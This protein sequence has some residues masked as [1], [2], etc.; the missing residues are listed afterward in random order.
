[1][2][3]LGRSDETCQRWK[4]TL[5]S[6]SVCSCL[7]ICCACMPVSDLCQPI[8][9]VCPD[10][11]L[12]RRVEQPRVC[13]ILINASMVIAHVSVFCILMCVRLCGGVAV[14]VVSIGMNACGS[15]SYTSGL[16]TFH[17][18]Y[19]QL[20]PYSSYDFLVFA[21]G[22]KKREIPL[23]CYRTTDSYYVV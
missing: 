22:Y 1:M 9:R 10:G 4:R 21:N 11:W 15:N 2:Q 20:Y 17:N 16:D 8:V 18:L 6:L 23:R 3:S 19:L 5:V 14:R 7:H 12:S 13:S